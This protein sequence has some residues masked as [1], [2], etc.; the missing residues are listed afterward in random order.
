M[1]K[2]KVEKSCRGISLD[3]Y[4]MFLFVSIDVATSH[5]WK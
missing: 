1:K 5:N 4:S 2:K 3:V